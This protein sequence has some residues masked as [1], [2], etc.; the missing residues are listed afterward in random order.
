MSI[1]YLYLSLCSFHSSTDNMTFDYI[2]EKRFF[3]LVN[4]FLAFPHTTIALGPAEMQEFILLFYEHF[5]HI[6]YKQNHAL[7]TV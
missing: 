7:D 4:L 5:F 6:Y 1:F 3:F 2:S